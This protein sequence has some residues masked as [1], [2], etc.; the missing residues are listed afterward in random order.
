VAKR[1]TPATANPRFSPTGEHA[2]KKRTVI[3]KLSD[4]FDR[5]FGLS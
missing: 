3:H 4:F 1:A 5:F 2:A